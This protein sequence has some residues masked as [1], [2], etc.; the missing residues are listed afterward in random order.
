[1]NLVQSFN[2]EQNVNRRR[3][4]FIS[5]R[6]VPALTLEGRASGR[7]TKSESSKLWRKN[8][9]NKKGAKTHSEVGIRTVHTAYKAHHG[10][11]ALLK[12]RFTRSSSR[13]RDGFGLTEASQSANAT[14]ETSRRPLAID[15]TAPG[16]NLTKT[17]TKYSKKS[18]TRQK[19]LNKKR[20]IWGV[21]ETRSGYVRYVPVMQADVPARTTCRHGLYNSMVYIG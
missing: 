9:R 4:S 11:L 2:V 8:E 10:F 14:P 21:D 3:G 12:Q 5:S 13:D 1:M 19:L 18:A 16:I 17:L 15:R 6:S 20:K 7:S